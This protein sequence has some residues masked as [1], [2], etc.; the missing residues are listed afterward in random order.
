MESNGAAA[1]NLFGFLTASEHKRIRRQDARAE[2]SLVA[3][4]VPARVA[5]MADA[6]WL[7]QPQGQHTAK[8][9]T[10]SWPEPN[11]LRVHGAKA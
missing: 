8:A 5:W 3:L 1:F 2:R 10:S 7:M 9:T 11:W 4:R 6:A